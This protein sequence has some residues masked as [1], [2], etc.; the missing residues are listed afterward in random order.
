MII[1]YIPVDADGNLIYLG[2]RRF[3]IYASPAL[4]LAAAG[5]AVDSKPV[6]V[7]EAE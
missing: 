6:Y 2:T 3:K 1:G 5:K 7:E 4:A